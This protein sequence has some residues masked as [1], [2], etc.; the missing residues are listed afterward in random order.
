MTTSKNSTTARKGHRR[1]QEANL[2]DEQHMLTLFAKRLNKV[3]D[4]HGY[5]SIMARRF[6]KLADELAVSPAGVRK[7]LVGIGMPSSAMLK[8][9][10]EKLAVSLD[11][12]FDVSL[13]SAQFD[14]EKAGKSVPVY[15]AAEAFDTD[16]LGAPRSA[17]QRNAIVSVIDGAMPVCP[18]SAHTFLV[19]C[20]IDAPS[21]GLQRGDLLVAETA[22]QRLADGQ[23]YLVRT[24]KGTTFLRRAT[25]EL[26]ELATF[27]P[28][29]QSA[30]GNSYKS[31]Q[32]AYAR[33]FSE[34]GKSGAITILGRVI[35][36][37]RVRY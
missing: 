22:L 19:E 18:D 1:A 24:G 25:I 21:A 3:L 13:P 14:P 28:M 8:T 23:I 34:N 7:W 11:W 15:S 17:F 29:E 31:S 26:N 16:T 4:S 32:I 36:T 20:W 9:I 35:G 6:T 37:C 33:S 30:K 27:Q 2:V 12:L 10:A 5:P